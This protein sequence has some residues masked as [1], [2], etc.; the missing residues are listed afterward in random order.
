VRYPLS[1]YLKSVVCT[2]LFHIRRMDCSLVACEGRLPRLYG[3]GQVKIG[4]RFVVRGRILPCELGAATSEA[5]LTIGDRVFIN[6]GASVVAY[7]DIEVGDDTLIGEF[8]TLYDTN[9]H[10]VDVD[11]PTKYGPVVIGS[12][13]WL[14]RDV[15]VLPGS[16]IGDHTIVAAGSIVKGE[17]PPRVLAS[18]NP[19]RPVRE[20]NIPDG[21]L[22]N[23]NSGRDIQVGFSPQ[24]AHKPSDISN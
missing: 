14:G 22:R 23:L 18:G 3:K 21:W 8:A 1:L 13:V 7:Y 6:Q 12:N 5:R 4:K 9:H 16:R 2:A 24:S 20:L 19:A 15:V 17:L 10:S 11:H